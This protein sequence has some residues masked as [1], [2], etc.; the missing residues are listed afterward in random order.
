MP[1][2][3]DTHGCAFLT[4]YSCTAFAASGCGG[5]SGS[6]DGAAKS[7]GGTLLTSSL[8]LLLGGHFASWTVGLAAVG[9]SLFGLGTICA[10]SVGYRN[11]AWDSEAD[12]IVAALEELEK[13]NADR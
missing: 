11:A 9:L 10:A 5:R 2:S 8:A 12:R 1:A 3:V 4:K 6:R 13:N 7:I